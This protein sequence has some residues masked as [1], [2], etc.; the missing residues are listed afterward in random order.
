MRTIILKSKIIHV[1]FLLA[2]LAY[3]QPVFAEENSSSPSLVDPNT[4]FILA[5]EKDYPPF[6]FVEGDEV[7][8]IALDYSKLI[9]SKLSRELKMT[10]PLQLQ[11]MLDMVRDGRANLLADITKTPERSKYLEFSD[12]YVNTPAG[13]I[14]RKG[15]LV[16][17]NK[18]TNT[19]LK[20]A[21][22][23]DYGVVSF[24][25]ERYPDA[26]YIELPSD[27]DVIKSV[28]LGASDVGVLDIGSLSYLL[29]QTPLSNIEVVTETGFEYSLSFAVSIE[30]K[31][32][33]TQINQVISTITQEER[34]VIYEKWLAT[35]P[36][37]KIPPVPQYMYVLLGAL[38]LAVLFFSGIS[39]LFRSILKKKTSELNKLNKELD[40]RV[41][42]IT[43]EANDLKSK[44]ELRNIDLEN[45]QKAVIN[46]LEDIKLEKDN[47]ASV[48]T[49][50]ELAT[51]S[52]KIG[53]W[54]WDVVN[55]VITWDDRMYALYGIKKEEF[56]GAYEAWQ[57]GLHPDDKKP[58]DVAIQ[59]ALKGEK[60]FSPQFRVVWANG[61]V[62]Y[63]QAH[64]IVERD[65]S[66][67]PLK[68]VGVNWDITKESVVDREKTEF[69]S[70]ASH[71]LKTP[72]GSIQWNMEMF[73]AGD[74][75]KISKK[76]KDVLEETYVMSTRMNDLVNALL[77]ISRIEMG[78][79]I[80][81]PKPTDFVELC[82]EVLVEMEPRLEKKG[83]KLVKN[84]D[85]DLTQI[86]ADDK[87]L[88]IVYQNFI[89]NAIK[90]TPNKGKIKI[91]LTKDDRN[92]TFSVANNGEPIPV[93]DQSKIFTKLFRASNAQEQ[94]PDGNGLGLYVVKQIVENAGGKVWFSSK[95]GEDTVFACSFPLSGMIAKSGTKQLS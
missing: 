2:F 82:E 39:L 29:Q 57:K 68:M 33:I 76:Q 53:V 60:D 66:G 90:Y 6:L 37:R 12:S 45:T 79:F 47:L 3:S 41:L 31:D 64:A 85:E 78:V 73:L 62:R 54:E 28:S 88:R 74:Y 69:V 35:V 80:I 50:L 83:H 46:I 72:I 84:F 15:E 95:K 20:I 92:V 30:N 48:S 61:E 32:V 40:K 36:E 71:Q 23:K 63:I 52:A 38:L 44:A 58:G 59:A 34:S 43:K 27:N 24:L 67:K 10:P 93:N 75:G 55:N 14:A 5:V 4:P 89:S 42:E 49:R 26:V 21:V 1:L 56:G 70:L 81:E 51:K 7:K 25:K 17:W 11:E 86:P 91:S 9:A 87:L 77:N 94:D 65:S 13:V 16:E 8:G 18:N 22:G 19:G